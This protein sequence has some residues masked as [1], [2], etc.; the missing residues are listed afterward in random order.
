[1]KRRYK[2]EILE[3]CVL[4]IFLPLLIVSAISFILVA[5]SHTVLP[6]RRFTS[7]FYG[8]EAYIVSSLWYGA[9]LALFSRFFLAETFF[10]SRESKLI[11]LY[12]LSLALVSI[13]LVSG[14]LFSLL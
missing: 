14:I 4:G 9:S 10:R 5:E 13:G 7:H 2:F 12:W 3:L 8:Y 11:P 6:L 1:M